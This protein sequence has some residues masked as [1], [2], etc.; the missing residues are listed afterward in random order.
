[1]KTYIVIFLFLLSSYSLLSQTLNLPSFGSDSTLEV[2]TWNIESFP[3]NGEATFDYIVDIVQSLD[4]D[5]IAFQEV[6]DTTAFK[7]MMNNL[8]EYGYSFRL[9]YYVGLAYI[10]KTETVQINNIYEIYNSYQYWSTFPRAPF[11]M[12]FNY[13]NQ[14]FIIINNHLK[15]CGDGVIDYSD[16]D[17][18]ENKRYNA[19]NLL[20]S[21]IDSYLS[22][23]NVFVVGDFNDEITDETQNNVFRSFI[24][25]PDD[26]LFADMGIAQ[27]NSSDWSYPAWPS[28]LD[29]ILITNEL[30][31]DFQNQDSDIQTQKID[32][33]LTNGWYE[34]SENV[35]DH[36]PVAIKLN[37][38]YNSGF[39]SAK[40]DADDFYI[41]PNPAGSGAEFTFETATGNS[42]IEIYN[43]AGQ[44]KDFINLKSGQTSAMWD[45]SNL[46]P[47]VYF[48]KLINGNTTEL[49]SKI[50]KL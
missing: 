40:Q 18:E 49:Y 23:N 32:Q 47:G 7:Q 16:S 15:C 37:T 34:Y 27:S 42:R 9:N 22:G 35:S 1:M 6:S 3:K 20:R 12:D 11:V 24:N 50:I 13:L 21:Y 38:S 19:V 43:A 33:Y 8:P 45:C 39:E 4:V 28:H 30:F 17:D 14:R 26:F 29:H 41:F 44:L 10:Y 25:Y 46:Q 48:A 31:N 36:R 2:V 5:I